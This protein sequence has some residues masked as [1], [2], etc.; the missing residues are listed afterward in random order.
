MK[1][2]LHVP[3]ESM[4]MVGLFIKMAHCNVYNHKHVKALVNELL[5]TF[6]WSALHETHNLHFV[7]YNSDTFAYFN[8]CESLESLNFNF[9]FCIYLANSAILS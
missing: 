4:C 7:F 3:F 8:T 5:M 9:A 6:L 2:C 1:T